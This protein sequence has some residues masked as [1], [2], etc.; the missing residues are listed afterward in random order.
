MHDRTP[1]C[2]PISCAVMQPPVAD[3]TAGCIFDNIVASYVVHLGA[4]LIM[5]Y[6]LSMGV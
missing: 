1:D 5:V 6:M 2:H 4:W 3:L